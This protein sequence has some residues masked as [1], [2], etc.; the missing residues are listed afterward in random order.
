MVPRVNAPLPLH[1][2]LL[3]A[4]GFHHAFF[5]RSGGVSPAP[6][7]SLNFSVSVGDDPANVHQ[8][9]RIAA[10]HLGVE[11]DK[12]LFLDQI[13]SAIVLRATSADDQQA[14]RITQGDAVVSSDA[15]VACAVRVA[16]C[17][18]VLLADRRSGTVA[19]IHSGWKSTAQNIVGAAVQTLRS[20]AGPTVD[21]IAA[22]G[23]HIEACCFEVGP[24]VAHSLAHA[25]SDHDV[26]LPGRRG[27]PHVDLRRVIHA[28]LLQAGVRPEDIDH[29]RGC[30]V[31]DHDRFFS[32]R[33]D[34]ARSGRM[35]AAIVAR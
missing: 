31:C 35:L 2:G 12:I 34:G 3:S 1:S 19:A 22:V 14:L 21:I 29:V 20:L 4:A 24:D 8:N 11:P 27:R 28:Q 23:P 13:H 26:V 32:Y 15:L 17:A 6:F 9:L 18:P 16:D 30:S 7:D 10:R 33:R 25:S 5:T